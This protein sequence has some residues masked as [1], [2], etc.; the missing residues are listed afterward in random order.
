MKYKIALTS[1]IWAPDYA[2]VRYFASRADQQS[3][4]DVANK[5]T[6]AVPERNLNS[7]TLLNISVYVKTGEAGLGDIMSNN[8]AIIQEPIVSGN[9]TTYKYYYY[10]ITNSTF[11]SVNQVRLDL[12]LD[13]FQTYYIDMTFG[14]AMI[15]RAHLNR[16][17]S[18][19]VFDNTINSNFLV[20]DEVQGLSKRIKNKVSAVCS[21]FAA[22]HA[23]SK[24]L[25]ANVLCWVYVYLDA[26]TYG[27]TNQFS[28]QLKYVRKLNAA[29][30]TTVES[31][32]VVLV[33]PLMANIL[34]NITFGTSTAGTNNIT[35]GQ[36]FDF[37]QTN[38]YMANVY[39][40]KLSAYAPFDSSV[41]YSFTASLLDQQATLNLYHAN[42]DHI[43]VAHNYGTPY[44]GTVAQ[45]RYQKLD[46]EYLTKE[47]TLPQASI[48]KTGINTY[49]LDQ[50]A[51][52]KS[53]NSDYR[54]LRI[55]YCGNQYDFDIQKLY[56][57]VSGSSVAFKY[58]EVLTPEIAPAYITITS[59]DN[60]IYNL[61]FENKIGYL[62][63][64]DL[65]IP[66]SKNQLE[67]FLANNKNFFMQKEETYANQRMTRSISAFS[68][69]LSGL[70]GAAMSGVSGNVGG[71]VAGG[72][73][74]LGNLA[75][76]IAQSEIAID[77][78]QQMTKYTLDN[79]QAGVDALANS[80]SNP[81]F[82]LGVSDLAIM[83][84][85]L[86]ALPIDMGRA[87]EDMHENGYSYNR[88]GNIKNFDNIRSKWNFVK[89]RV[90]IIKTPVKIPNAAREQIRVAFARGV[91]F[92]NTDTVSFEQI[93]MEK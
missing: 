83:I 70:G 48:L 71:A 11:D 87:L 60:A 18:S 28:E 58:F 86:E 36:L 27:D 88:M 92:W 68:N 3:Y 91:R 66:Y 73:S 5:F 55:A 80:N 38:N 25:D 31:P 56:G 75:T 19:G 44:A 46:P 84:E 6:S 35:A 39:A 4:F 50:A 67:V 21:P 7:G 40:I 49:S 15:E 64:N 69:V 41:N 14:D 22:S 43:P 29:A 77:Y 23:V 10:F 90:E 8:Y 33:A 78:D 32:Y 65:S 54:G 2:N 85:E 81:F 59:K 26:G 52:P 37:L 30:Q 16:W 47:Y 42:D 61:A 93:N 45:V 57:S 1:V 82:N 9:S 62:A 17:N 79:M 12:Q 34:H 24:W 53:Y 72:I 13:I 74:T 89:A 63:Q 20:R 51:N 76:T